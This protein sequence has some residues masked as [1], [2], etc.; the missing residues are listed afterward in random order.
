M[1]LMAEFVIP[2]LT[3]AEL[4]DAAVAVNTDL[5]YNYYFVELAFA[6]AAAVDAK[7]YIGNFDDEEIPSDYS[8]YWNTAAVVNWTAAAAE[9]DS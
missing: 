2:H 7:L 1:L 3:R 6:A 4:N 9:N 8:N 5:A